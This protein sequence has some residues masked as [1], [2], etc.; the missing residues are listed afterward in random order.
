[1]ALALQLVLNGPLGPVGDLNL[2]PGPVPQPRLDV[3]KPGLL[4]RQRRLEF[5]LVVV[6]VDDERDDQRVRVGHLK[7]RENTK[8]RILKEALLR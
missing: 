5:H 1:M 2:R 7:Q 6:V 8:E 4:V 3:G